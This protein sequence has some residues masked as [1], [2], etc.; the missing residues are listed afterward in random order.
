M[1]I[2]LNKNKYNGSK[3]QEEE[4]EDFTDIKQKEKF[5]NINEKDKF[6]N[7][8]DKRTNNFILNLSEFRETRGKFV[9][10]C[11]HEMQY[12]LNLSKG[13]ESELINE[14][15]FKCKEKQSFKDLNNISTNSSKIHQHEFVD[16][17]CSSKFSK[18]NI[19]KIEG[20]LENLEEKYEED[21]V[22]E[23]LKEDFCQQHYNFISNTEEGINHLKRDNSFVKV[24]YEHEE[25][26]EITH[27]NLEYPEICLR[28]EVTGQCDDIDCGCSHRPEDIRKYREEVFN[29]F[30]EENMRIKRKI[31]P[32]DQ[33]KIKKLLSYAKDLKHSDKNNIIFIH[34]DSI[35]KVKTS[36]EDKDC[37]KQGVII[38]VQSED[39]F[40]YKIEEIADADL[41]AEVDLFSMKISIRPENDCSGI[42]SD[43]NVQINNRLH[44]NDIKQY[45]ET[46]K[47]KNENFR[48]VIF[49]SENFFMKDHFMKGV[50]LLQVK[51][52]IYG[53]ND[54]HEVEYVVHINKVKLY[55]YMKTY[56]HDTL[57]FLRGKVKFRILNL[58]SELCLF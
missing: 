46:F 19:K 24:V 55:I 14:E 11:Y 32:Y 44:L 26:T 39:T 45:I 35:D 22:R 12:F 27:S 31:L 17:N 23:Y 3:H 33:N 38:D 1:N 7:Q 51:V 5:K 8:F 42:T 58:M 2:F 10:E 48:G 16:S 29:R 50:D 4:R 54:E 57:Y 21:E 49:N 25:S 47:L 6:H 30:N 56:S 28:L 40:A 18:V 9:E 15:Y 36:M 43:L 20:F 13:K 41:K 52:K 34:L 53:N 37:F